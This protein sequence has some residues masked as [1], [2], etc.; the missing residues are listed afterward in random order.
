MEIFWLM[1]AS[2]CSSAIT[3]ILGAGGGL[4][5]ISLM[6]VALPVA[7]IVPV[8]GVAQLASNIS[9]GLFA[10]S[11]IQWTLVRP[12]LAGCALGTVAGSHLLVR[13]PTD[14]LPVPLGLFILIMTWLPQV[15]RRFWLPG[16]FF[17]LGL[18]QAVLTLFVGATGPLNMPFLLREGLSRDQIVVTGSALMT[19]VHLVKIVAFG[20]LGFAFS[21]Y[22]PLIV[23]LVIAVTLGSYAGTRLRTHVSE[24]LFARI[25]KLV[26][27]LLA[28]R[29]IIKALLA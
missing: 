2:F 14:F 12:F 24:A 22:W 11:H 19:I 29:M 23:G 18:A 21:P 7:A 25:Y 4:L 26:I 9:R 8:H 3:A 27:T 16:R 15:K 17:S 6:A 20:L 5:L 28:G 10:L 1:G 13:F